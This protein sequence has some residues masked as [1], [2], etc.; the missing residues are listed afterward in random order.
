MM[1][2][3]PAALAVL[4]GFVAATPVAHAEM[5]FLCEGGRIAYASDATLEKLKREDACVAGY[6]S[7]K[8][9]TR[10]LST[11]ARTPV[12]AAKADPGDSAAG[13]ALELRPSSAREVTRNSRSTARRRFNEVAV[14]VQPASGTAPQ[15][16]KVINAAGP[17]T[18]GQ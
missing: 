7:A 5:A 2:P 12:E 4:A 10:A 15:P 8:A 13:Q 6:Y 17:V 11:E 18:S 16:L 9:D 1:R 14:P 3:V